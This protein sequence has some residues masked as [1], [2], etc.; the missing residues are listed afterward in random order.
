MA[1]EKEK[2]IMKPIEIKVI[3]KVKKSSE[4]ICS[5]FLNTERWSDFKGYS[6]LPGIKAAEFTVKTSNLVGSR[7]K[8]QNTYDSSHVEEIIEWDIKNRIALK[9]QDFS[10]PLNKFATYFIEVW[11][12]NAIENGTKIERSM[13]MYPKGFL[14]WIILLPISQLMKK[15]FEK[16]SI[17]HKD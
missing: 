4:E 1:A 6:I 11:K 2:I 15:A 13:T 7:I 14:G 16:H 17:E 10:A 3:G 9:F 8:V 5:L 12:F